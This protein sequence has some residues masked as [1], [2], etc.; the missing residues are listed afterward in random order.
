MAASNVQAS[1]AHRAGGLSLDHEGILAMADTPRQT[2]R[3]GHAEE[4]QLSGRYHPE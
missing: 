3:V 4:T 2:G 1:D